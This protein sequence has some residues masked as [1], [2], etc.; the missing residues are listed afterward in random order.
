MQDSSDGIC[1]PQ[2]A[3]ISS[4]VIFCGQLSDIRDGSL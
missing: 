4:G 1:T 3:M 2:I